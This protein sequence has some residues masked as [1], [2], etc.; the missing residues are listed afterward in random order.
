[1]RGA[2]REAMGAAVA[3]EAAR[4]AAEE[5]GGGAGYPS[6]VS[7]SIATM[8]EERVNIDAIAALVWHLDASREEG[9]ILVFMPGMHEIMALHAVLSAG[10]ADA[11]TL[12]PL[13]LH[14]S[15]SSQ[16]QLAVFQRPP[17]R[18]R[19]VVIA[20]NIAETSITIDD[21]IIVIDSGRAKV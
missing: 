10:T 21:V 8:D 3:R 17:R 12:L 9:A 16:E 7:E 15:I 18:L 4:A 1:M 6:H 14:S 2:A 13:P 5:A 20:T 19:K 11:R